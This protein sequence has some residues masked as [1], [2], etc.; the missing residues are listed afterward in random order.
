MSEERVTG[1]DADGLPGALLLAR[2]L[3]DRV[4]G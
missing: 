4:A 3:A 1:H 2:E